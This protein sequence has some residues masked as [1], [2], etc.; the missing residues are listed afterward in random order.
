MLICSHIYMR[1]ETIFLRL[2][3]QREYVIG[4]CLGRTENK[5]VISHL[6]FFFYFWRLMVL[7]VGSKEDQVFF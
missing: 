2:A 4:V 5:C 6:M 7:A 3:L 1:Q